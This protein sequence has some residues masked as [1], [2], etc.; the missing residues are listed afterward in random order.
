[1]LSLGRIQTDS[2]D[3]RIYRKIS[4]RSTKKYTRLHISRCP[5]TDARSYGIRK[6]MPDL[7]VPAKRS[8]NLIVSL[9]ESEANC[10]CY[11]VLRC[12]AVSKANLAS[13]R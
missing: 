2:S 10:A 8:L 12:S 9:C 1:M 3:Q 5:G 4:A 6:R 13:E 11:V 7:A